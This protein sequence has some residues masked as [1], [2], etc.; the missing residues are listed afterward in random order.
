MLGFRVGRFGDRDCGF[1]AQALVLRNPGV[2]L[3][4]A[5]GSGLISRQ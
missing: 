5:R 4:V 2:A 3:A 1:G